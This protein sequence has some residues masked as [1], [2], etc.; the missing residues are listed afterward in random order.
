MF[1]KNLLILLGVLF[2]FN[3]LVLANNFYL[4]TFIGINNLNPIKEHNRKENF[5][6]SHESFAFPSV[7]GGFGYYISDKSRVDLIFQK[8]NFVFDQDSNNFNYQKNNTYVTGAKSV[9]RRVTGHALTLNYYVD[10]FN[11]ENFFKIFV[12]TGVGITQIKERKKYLSSGNFINDGK[13]YTFLGVV[14]KFD[15]TRVRNFTYSLMIG[16]S[17][18]INSVANLDLTYGWR[19]YG[20]TKVKLENITMSHAYKG[21]HLSL[22]VRFDF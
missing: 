8:I 6:L 19:D 1:K 13:V 10:I 18:K 20:K 2:S 3:Q 4:T 14:D 12:G 21:H 15:G 16:V 11:K 5:K 7:G 22:G 17:K 9:E